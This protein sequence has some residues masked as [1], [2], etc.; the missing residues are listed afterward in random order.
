MLRRLAI[1]AACLL[2]SGLAPFIAKIGLN[3]TISK[4]GALALL[5]LLFWLAAIAALGVLSIAWVFDRRIG[6][7][8]AIVCCALGAI[9]MIALPVLWPRDFSGALFIELLLTFPSVRLAIHL[10]R[11]HSATISANASNPCA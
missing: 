7:T 5:V 2:L 6:R 4:H 10:S 3:L 1:V 9:G 11:F 8:A